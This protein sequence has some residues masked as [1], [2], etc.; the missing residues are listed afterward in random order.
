MVKTLLPFILAG[1]QPSDS[2]PYFQPN[3]E[4]PS[5]ATLEP[6]S[7]SLLEEQSLFVKP[8]TS[9]LIFHLGCSTSVH[10]LCISFSVAPE[11]LAIAHREGHPSFL[12]CHEIISGPDLFK[13]WLSSCDLLSVTVCS[14]LFFKQKG[15]HF[16]VHFNQCNHHQ[17]HFL[18]WCLTFCSPCLWIEKAIMLWCWW[19]TS[20]LRESP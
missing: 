16:I 15:M 4:P 2:D 19:R 10:W 1:A 5:N 6:D 14:A 20:F 3:L 13:I 7:V 18:H 11:F 9:G 12:R 17:F 8:A